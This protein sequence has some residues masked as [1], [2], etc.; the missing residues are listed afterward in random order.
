MASIIRQLDA[1]RRLEEELAVEKHRQELE[2]QKID[3]ELEGLRRS[4]KDYIDNQIQ[5]TQKD[6]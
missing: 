3:R 6:Y 4:R 5:S 1:S 2:R